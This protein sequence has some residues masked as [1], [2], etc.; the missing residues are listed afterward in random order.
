MGSNLNNDCKVISNYIEGVFRIFS[1][2]RSSESE[3]S[4]IDGFLS[5]ESESETNTN[6]DLLKCYIHC[7]FKSLKSPGSD[8][9][10]KCSKRL[11]DY[12]LNSSLGM[13][14]VPVFY[15]FMYELFSYLQTY[16]PKIEYES[17][18]VFDGDLI[19]REQLVCLTSISNIDWLHDFFEKVIRLLSSCD[20]D[21]NDYKQIFESLNELTS[22]ISDRLAVFNY[23]YGDSGN[24]LSDNG[25]SEFIESFKKLDAA[26][27]G[28]QKSIGSSNSMKA[29]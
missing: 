12:F 18:K 25:I 9:R 24:T 23:P 6:N 11:A 21:C 29:K 16:L 3:L 28:N 17:A 13:D 19:N 14:D 20:N 8:T 15:Y 26:T 4:L 27:K 5:Q 1:K 22:K 7:F 2:D 10:K